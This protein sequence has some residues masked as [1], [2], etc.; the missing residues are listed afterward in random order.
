MMKMKQTICLFVLSFASV[1]TAEPQVAPA[2]TNARSNLLAVARKYALE[3]PKCRAFLSAI[4]S[5]PQ[6]N[7]N[8]PLETVDVHEATRTVR[9]I[10]NRI[11]CDGP[12]H[13]ITIILKPDG[14]L[15]AAETNTMFGAEINPEP[16]IRT[17]KN[18]PEKK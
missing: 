13:T 4:S 16:V 2:E 12:M 11:P 17:R 9:F 18:E 1:A 6:V 10:H 14:T 15:R 7:T 8:R 5:D 3:D